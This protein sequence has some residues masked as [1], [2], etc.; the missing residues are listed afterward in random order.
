MKKKELLKLLK[1]EYQRGYIDALTYK[2]GYTMYSL[3]RAY[4]KYT[5]DNGLPLK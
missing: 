3:N 1:R 5:K 2:S 4:K